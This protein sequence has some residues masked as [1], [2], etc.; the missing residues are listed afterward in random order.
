MTAMHAVHSSAINTA[1]TANTQEYAFYYYFYQDGTI[2]F[3]IKLTGELSTNMLS[4]G[5]D[6]GAPRFGLMVAP[7]VNSQLH[8]HMFAARLDMAVDD[9]EGGRGLEVVEVRL[10][11]LSW[12]KKGGGT[13]V[14]EQTTFGPLASP[15]SQLNTENVFHGLF[16]APAENAG[17]RLFATPA[18]FC[19]TS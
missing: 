2:G 4:P 7:G 8:Q 5:E 14:C 15:S 9:E 19:H 16:A 12:G 13:V 10:K 1:D 18:E 17:P 6:P 3:E 11:G